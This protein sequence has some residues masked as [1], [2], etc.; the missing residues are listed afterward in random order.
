[1]VWGRGHHVKEQGS[2]GTVAG[3]DMEAVKNA[4]HSV[5]VNAP[6]T[7]T[8]LGWNKA[9][10]CG[11]KWRP[12]K[13]QQIKPVYSELAIPGSQPPS[14]VFGRL[15]GRQRGGKAL[16]WKKGKPWPGGSVSWSIILYT[17]KLWFNSWSGH[18]PRLQVPSLV[19]AQTGGKLSMFLSHTDV[20]SLSISLSLHPPPFI[21][22]INKHVWVKI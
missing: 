4:G 19:E 22:K 21:S 11:N 7:A 9:L 14:F 6:P 1:M 16:P 13:S 18:I 3:T 10:K 8:C 15:K 20:L 17:K 5:L 2:V 12:S